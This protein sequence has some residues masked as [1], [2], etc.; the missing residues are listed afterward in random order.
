MSLGILRLVGQGVIYAGFAGL[1]GYFAAAPDYRY[2]PDDRAE[3]KLSFSHGGQ[4]R[5]CRE[6]TAAEIAKMPPNMRVTRSC[7][8]ERLPVVLEVEIDDKPLYRAVLPPSGVSK[9][10]PSR[11]YQRFGVPTGQHRLTLTLIDSGR[12]SGFDYARTIDVELKGR[13]NLV[14]DFRPESGGFVL[15]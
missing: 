11:V 6:L 1:V 15:R 10:G 7:S 4:R 3:I 9:D 14:V 8:R 5:D 13:Q 2:R 12:S